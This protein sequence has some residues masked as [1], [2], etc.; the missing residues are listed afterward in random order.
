MENGLE[1][2]VNDYLKRM[3]ETEAYYES[4]DF[5]QAMSIIKRYKK[6]D[7]D[8][9]KYGAKTIKGLPEEKFRKVVETVLYRFE[10]NLIHGE[11]DDF[12]VYYTDYNGIRFHLMIGQGSTYWT[13]KIQ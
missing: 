8:E 13:T 10:S 9:L 2:A 1:K 11:G 6:I 5:N 7:Q 12:P 3:E 4:E